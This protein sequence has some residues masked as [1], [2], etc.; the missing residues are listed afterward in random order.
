MSAKWG[1]NFICGTIARIKFYP[2][3]GHCDKISSAL[4]NKNKEGK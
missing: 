1:L 3:C 2:Y 4:R